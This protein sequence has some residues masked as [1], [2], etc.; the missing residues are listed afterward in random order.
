MN[1]RELVSKAIEAMKNA[2][3]PYSNCFVGAALLCESGAVYTGCNVENASFGATI[4]AERTAV[5]AAVSKGERTFTAIAVAGGKNGDITDFFPP[6]GICRQVLSEFA[7][8]DMRVILFNGKEIQGFA[9]RDLMPL[10]FL[11]DKL[12]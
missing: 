7:S 11:P 10:S 12:K 3:A 5:S 9:F 1:D 4:C 6:C 8:D 2:Y